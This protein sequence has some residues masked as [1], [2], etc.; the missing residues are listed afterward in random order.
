M[1]AVLEDVC[2][3]DAHRP[4]TS[5]HAVD[6]ISVADYRG[7]AQTGKELMRIDVDIPQPGLSGT[8]QTFACRGSPAVAIDIEPCRCSRVLA[9]GIPC[10]V[11][12]FQLI[13]EDC[14]EIP[15]V[16]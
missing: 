7:R 15:R 10:H 16:G 9:P 3:A 5:S 8:P 2:C 11:N 4:D 12:V 6:L 14:S 13:V 1:P